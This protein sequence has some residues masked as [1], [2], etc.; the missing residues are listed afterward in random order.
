ML[1]VFQQPFQL[2]YVASFS[3]V[4]TF[5]AQSVTTAPFFH[6]I[7][8]F[9]PGMILFVPLISQNAN[10]FTVSS[11]QYLPVTKAEADLSIPFAFC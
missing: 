5:P 9:I 11:S 3:E 6:K 7:I 1:S 2:L 10:V 4:T 8:L